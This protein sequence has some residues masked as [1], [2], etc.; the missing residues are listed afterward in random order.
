VVGCTGWT[1]DQLKALHVYSA[2][3]PT[4]FAPNF[5]PGV[6]LMLGLIEKA[7]PILKAWGY[8]A[9]VH[10][11]HHARKID[12]PSGTAKAIVDALGDLKH[13]VHSS[14]AGNIVGTHEVR[15]VGTGDILTLEHEA[16][17]RAIFARGAILAAEWA[18][19]QDRPGLYSM[20]DVIFGSD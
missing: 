1:P 12:A 2:I 18:S 4:V 3:A 20:K 6:N 5:S 9:V 8:D 19:R 15:F 16:L 17:D 11:T 14:R 10:E 7:A 13:Q